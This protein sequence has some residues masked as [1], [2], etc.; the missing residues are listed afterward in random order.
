M[1]STGAQA[2][3]VSDRQY[4]AAINLY[5]ELSGWDKDGK[6]T[7]GKLVDLNLDWLID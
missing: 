7:P 4:Q 6:P 5:Y 1:W 2:A 3:E